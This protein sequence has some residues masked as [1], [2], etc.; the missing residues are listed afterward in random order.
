MRANDLVRR[1]RDL[2]LAL[3]S[4]LT[5]TGVAIVA[6]R[7]WR[8]DLH[9]PIV[10]EGDATQVIGYVQNMIETGSPSLSSR[11]GAPFGQQYQ[12]FPLGTDNLNFGVMKL[13]SLVT[14][15]AVATVNVFYF[16]TFALVAVAAYWA[17]RALGVGRPVCFVAAVVYALVPFH[18]MRGT[19]H[20]FLSAYFAVPLAAYIL[21]SAVSGKPLFGL[22]RS[23]EGSSKFVRWRPSSRSS[24]LAKVAVRSS[25]R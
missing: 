4:A 5:A 3:A 6:L 17:L 11:L 19:G 15:D 16:L 8:L 13:I 24:T 22:G 2:W 21:V 1:H 9:S 23:R 12:D 25:F 14:G 7:A 20:L 18:F 10:L